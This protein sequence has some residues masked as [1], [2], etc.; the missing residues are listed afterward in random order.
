MIKQY[1]S[2]ELGLDSFAKYVTSIELLT[3]NGSETEE[4]TYFQNE[5]GYIPFWIGVMSRNSFFA[6]KEGLEYV[7]NRILRLNKVPMTSLIYKKNPISQY[8]IKSSISQDQCRS[9]VWIYAEMTKTP[10]VENTS[11]VVRAAGNTGRVNFMYASQE[12]D[13][14]VPILGAGYLSEAHLV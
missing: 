14:S 9:L 11:I 2:S 4:W 1:N 10:G 8:I 3:A 13:E 6:A 5:A 7:L 12:D